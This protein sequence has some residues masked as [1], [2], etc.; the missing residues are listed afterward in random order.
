MARPCAGGPK[1]GPE[2]DGHSLPRT[3][4]T[5][6]GV[7]SFWPIHSR[8]LGEVPCLAELQLRSYDLRWIWVNYCQI[9]TRRPAKYSLHVLFGLPPAFP[10]S[11]IQCMPQL[12]APVLEPQVGQL[13]GLKRL[14]DF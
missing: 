12:R 2:T 14:A 1:A 9:N 11:A 5:R 8:H 6:L 3:G 13:L 4:K 10:M 7:L